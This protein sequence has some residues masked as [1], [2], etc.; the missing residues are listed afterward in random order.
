MVEGLERKEPNSP[1]MKDGEFIEEECKFLPPPKSIPHPRLFMIKDDVGY[2]FLNYDQLKYF[3]RC[4]NKDKDTIKTKKE[5][6]INN[7]DAISHLFIKK[8]TNF[9]S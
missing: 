5:I 6:K 8:Y 1:R 9:N 3:F 2:E 7:E 4:K